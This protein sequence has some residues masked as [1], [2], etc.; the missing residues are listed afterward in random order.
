MS[1]CK[2]CSVSIAGHRSSLDKTLDILMSTGV[3]HPDELKKFYSD[4]SAFTPLREEN[5]YL[6]M[7]GALSAILKNSPS[8]PAGDFDFSDDEISEYIS[9]ASQTGEEIEK[10]I[11]ETRAELSEKK[12]YHHI[13]KQFS[14]INV[15]LENLFACEY[16]YVSFGMLSKDAYEKFK[17][18]YSKT[19]IIFYPAREDNEMCYGV[20]FAPMQQK[21]EAKR[22]FSSLY[23]EKLPIKGEKGTPLDIAQ[24]LEKQITQLEE[25]LKTL[26]EKQSAHA[27]DEKEKCSC[28]LKCVLQRKKAF[29]L[30]KYAA[31]YN[32]RF[33]ICGWCPSDDGEMLRNEILK[34]DGNELTLE[35]LGKETKLSPPVK[36]KNNPLVRPYEYYVGMY[37][38]PSYKESD[39]TAFVAI[40][41]T[42]LFGIMFGDLGQGLVLSVIGYLMWKLKKM[43][44]GKI[45]IPCGISSAVFGLIYGSVFGFEELLDPMFH[46]LGFSE[47]PIDVMKPATTQM[48]IYGAVGAGA[49]LVLI[50]IIMNIFSCIKQKKTAHSLFSSN[51]VAG[52]LFYVSVLSLLLITGASSFAIP[53]I[54]LTLLLMFFCEPLTR[55][56]E[57]KKPL[58]EG[59]SV[60]DFAMQTF[61]EVFETVLSYV[62][63]TMSFLRVGAF[64]LVHAGMMKVVFTLAEMSSGAPYVIILI[65]GNALVLCL[66]ALLVGIQ[67][68][69]LEFYEMFSRFYTGEGEAYTPVCQKETV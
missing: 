7:E 39:P 68:L 26:T 67:V 27:K 24:D 6:A 32:D 56:C 15:D 60:S 14:G 23:F 2:M 36:L 1:V 53:I 10:A 61:F 18:N 31:L 19:D 4:I 66:E 9:H 8:L 49:L 30:R 45:L 34:I 62:T 25:K 29:E 43:P 11:S 22:I 52:I 44:L 64:I 50:S 5:P 35:P 41:Y 55:L 54:V 47:K 63:N 42:L 12:K 65:V 69:R 48:I 13:I 59:Q 21:E 40:T 51:G 38:L 20:Y 57:K 3:F 33:I 17:D 46:A 37:G 28:M 16:T 58:E